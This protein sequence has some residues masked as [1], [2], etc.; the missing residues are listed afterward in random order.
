M[1]GSDESSGSLLQRSSCA[2]FWRSPKVKR[3]ISIDHFS[4]DGTLIEASASIW[5]ASSTEAASIDFSRSGN[6]EMDEVNGDGSVELQPDGS[7]HGEICYHNGHDWTF[8]A[9]RWASSTAC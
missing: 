7:L 8:I 4:V 5:Q 9:R 2:P 1:R 6:D 3:L